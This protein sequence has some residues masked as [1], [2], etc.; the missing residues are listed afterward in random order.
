MLISVEG[1]Y[2]RG[3]LVLFRPE[4]HPRSTVGG[5]GLNLE[6]YS[7]APDRKETGMPGLSGRDV[8][9]LYPL[10]SC[11]LWPAFEVVRPAG[12][13]RRAY[14]Q[15]NNPF[16]REVIALCCLGI[17]A[18]SGWAIR[19]VSNNGCFQSVDWRGPEGQ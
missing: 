19:G 17:G 1:L 15:S 13:G 12:L 16:S 18:G 5:L 8:I 7:V 10:A 2:G 4:L 14:E 3:W 11:Q 6:S 9:T